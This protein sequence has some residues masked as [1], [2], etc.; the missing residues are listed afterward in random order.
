[1]QFNLTYFVT[2]MLPNASIRMLTRREFD[3][4]EHGMVKIE[5]GRAVISVWKKSQ[6][7]YLIMRKRWKTCY[8]YIPCH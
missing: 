2:L 8:T 3:E 5:N 7:T 6:I 1:M 4:M